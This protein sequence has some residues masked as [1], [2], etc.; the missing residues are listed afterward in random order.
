MK[1]LH[2]TTV[3]TIV[4]RQRRKTG[5]LPCGGDCRGGSR[6][7][8]GAFTWVG[9]TAYMFLHLVLIMRLKNTNLIIRINGSPGY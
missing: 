9:Y 3:H 4:E 8:S 6:V 2:S 1:G 7:L 5:L